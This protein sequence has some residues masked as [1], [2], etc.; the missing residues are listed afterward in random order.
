[1]RYAIGIE[2]D[3]SAFLGWQIQRQEPTVQGVLE[4]ALAKV[5]DHKVR[6]T[7][8]GRT[9]SG[10]HALC[11]VAHFDSPSE[12]SERSWVLGLNSHLPDGVSVLWIRPVDEDFHARFSAFARSYRYRILN[13]W[14]RPAIEHGRASWVRQALDADAMH[15]AA[16]HLLGEHDFSSFRAS[17]C[18]ATHPVREIHAI[19]VERRVD[20]VTLEVTA[21]AFLYHMV[22]NIAGSLIRVG[23]GEA[24]PG[25]LREV[26][27]A[28]DR[29]Q[30]A[31]TAQ[32][33]GLYF[34]GA[35]FPQ[36]YGLPDEAP[37]FPRGQGLS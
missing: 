2:Y 23:K 3:G 10:V 36:H 27:A 20:V 9:D 13:R 4:H 18:Q 15:E 11:Q 17:N 29:N 21:N 37:P 33:D 24:P 14:I 6:I 12:R 8:C 32:P 19:S 28:K 26:L 35:R 31:P 5:A 30:A 1:M 25:W 34:L 22:R 16:Q 7:A